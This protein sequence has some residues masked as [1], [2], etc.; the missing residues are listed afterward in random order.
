MYDPKQSINQRYSTMDNAIQKS[1]YSL[2]K[3]K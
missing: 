1:S 3:Q 2:G